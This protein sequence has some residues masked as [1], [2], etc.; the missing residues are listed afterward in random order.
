M[1][2]RQYL[3]VNPRGFANEFSIYHVPPEHRAEA[4]RWVYRITHSYY[5]ND[6]VADA[7]WI[8]RREAEKI[9]AN[10]RYQRRQLDAAGLSNDIVG[11]TEIT[12][13]EPNPY[14]E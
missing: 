14:E 7:Y 8:T 6:N 3:Y 9:T 12:E 2:Q 5:T 11:A 10:Q 1:T 13:W 4:D